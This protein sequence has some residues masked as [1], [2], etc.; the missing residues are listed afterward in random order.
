MTPDLVDPDEQRTSLEDDDLKHYLDDS[1]VLLDEDE[2][3]VR[4]QTA[5]LQEFFLH[6]RFRYEHV[7]YKDRER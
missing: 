7:P 5:D 4:R 3:L 2:V 6:R 1:S